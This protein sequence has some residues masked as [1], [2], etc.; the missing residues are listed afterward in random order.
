[1]PECYADTL[2]IE[3]LVPSKNGYNHKHS[4]FKVETEMTK[5]MLR[6]RFAVGIIDNDK[7]QIKYLK[8]FDIVDKIEG[9][10]IL[11][12]NRDKAKHHF[13]IQICPALERWILNI[14]G[15]EN[16]V[17]AEFGIASDLEGLKK[18]TKSI[19]SLEDEK[20]KALFKEISLKEENISIRKLKNWIGLLK[21]KN[22]K[23]DINEL[24][25]G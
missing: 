18:Y 15:N 5:G 17:L 4:C 11:W 24:K 16:I 19:S 14:C 25:N 6:D 2:L 10:L 12:R 20:L 1:M 9:S 13:I 23:V 22:Y 21:E 8:D 3:A 7:A